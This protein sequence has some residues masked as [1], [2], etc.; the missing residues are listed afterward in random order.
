MNVLARHSHEKDELTLSTWMASLVGVS[1]L[2]STPVLTLQ[3]GSGIWTRKVVRRA[4]STVRDG[5]R[6]L[7]AGTLKIELQGT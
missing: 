6:D 4:A 2:C 1:R 7:P 5:Q 3:Q